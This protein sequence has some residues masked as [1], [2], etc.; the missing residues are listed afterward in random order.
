MLQS[1]GNAEPKRTLLFGRAGD[2]R[3]PTRQNPL[4]IIH[5]WRIPLDACSA[6][7]EGWECVL[8]PEEQARAARF[9]FAA[10]RARWVRTR[11]V[12]RVLLGHYAHCPPSAVPLSVGAYGKP[13][14]PPGF[15]PVP[16][17]FNW[18]HA[19]DMALLALTESGPVGVDVER[20][21]LDFDPLPLAS[22]VF[23][24]GEMACLRNALPDRHHALF[25]AFW[26][27]KEAI[28]KALGVGLSM[29][30]AGFCVADLARRG[31]ACAQGVWVRSLPVG[32]HHTAALACA[33][34]DPQI[35]WHDWH[36]PCIL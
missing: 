5:L 1:K 30:P 19:E 26:T 14:L 6:P 25:F 7:P 29:P 2:D 36:D 8:T 22:G 9:R 18:S 27:A 33:H 31:H 34:K 4:P 35:C 17:H 13:A 28:L 12:V 3:M 23:S 20:I 11:S 15:R 24:P 16:L 10:D 32:D 21:R